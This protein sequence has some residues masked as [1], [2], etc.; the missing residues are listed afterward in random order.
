MVLNIHLWQV[1]LAGNSGSL[2]GHLS[3]TFGGAPNFDVADSLDGDYLGPFNNL[4]NINTFLLVR[5][6]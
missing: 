2:I 3:A 4:C 6:I 5:F 1:S